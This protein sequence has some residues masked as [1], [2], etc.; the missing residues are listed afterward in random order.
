MMNKQEFLERLQSSLSGLPK[1]DVEEQLTFYSEMIDDRVEEG[2]TEQQAIEEIGDI[3]KLISQII[4][5]VPLTKLVKE[6]MK[7][8]RKHKAWETVLL[9]LGFPVWGSLLIA[10]FAVVFSLYLVLWCLIVCCWAVFLSLA[11]SA[12]ALLVGGVG[13]CITHN[14]AGG[15]ACIGA[16]FVVAALSI[17]AFIGSQAATKG[18]CRLTGKL[19]V[20]IKHCFAKKE[21]A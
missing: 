18:I 21:D 1:A 5:D 2:V 11:A 9:I 13:F 19:T 3:D 16:G 8:K 7:P 4:A 12:A 10:A 15:I 20:F 6:K 14:S 17:F